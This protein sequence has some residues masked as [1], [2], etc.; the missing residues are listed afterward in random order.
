[1]TIQQLVDKINEKLKSGE[2]HPSMRVKFDENEITNFPLEYEF[3]YLKF[4]VREKDD[5]NEDYDFDDG[6]K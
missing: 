1:M 6:D 4:K 3:G 2:F 5:Y